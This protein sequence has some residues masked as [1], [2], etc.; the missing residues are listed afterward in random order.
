MSNADSGSGAR[1]LRLGFPV[2]VMG[3]PELKSHDTRRWQKNPHLKCSLE[4]VDRILDYLAR[5][6]PPGADG[7]YGNGHAQATGGALCP[8]DWNAFVQ[9][10]GFPDQQVPA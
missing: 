5:H 4:H 10:I 8:A 1:P 9:A 6:R 3:R 2:K 7:R